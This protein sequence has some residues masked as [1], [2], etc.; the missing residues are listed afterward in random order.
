MLFGSGA[1]AAHSASGLGLRG[2]TFGGDW[3]IVLL[4][5]RVRLSG[6]RSGWGYYTE[7]FHKCNSGSGIDGIRLYHQN[8]GKRWIP[9]IHG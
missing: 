6:K 7:S 3:G 4:A 5:G 9:Y 1:W 2:L 8:N